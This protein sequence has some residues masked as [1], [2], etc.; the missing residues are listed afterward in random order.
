[1]VWQPKGNCYAYCENS[2]AAYASEASG[3]YGLYNFDYQ[4]YIG[5]S[6]NIRAALLQHLGEIEC[7]PARFQP[8]GFAFEVC[9][10]EL[11]AAKAERLIAEHCPVR[12]TEWPSAD[13]WDADA[14]RREESSWFFSSPAEKSLDGA[15]HRVPESETPPVIRKRFYFA[16]GQVAMLTVMFALSLAVIFFLGILTGESIQKKAS[17]GYEAPSVNISDT[18]PSDQSGAM[19][20]SLVE[21]NPLDEAAQSSS[22]LPVQPDSHVASLEP[23]RPTVSSAPRKYP[24]SVPVIATAGDSY[25]NLATAAE[26]PTSSRPA[27]VSGGDISWAVQLAANREKTVA[28]EQVTKLK[29]KGYDGYMVETE[30]DGQIWYRVRVGRFTTRPEAEALRGILASREDYRSPFI[31]N[32]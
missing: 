17:A 16:R 3:V 14:D 8:T 9:A 18:A 4:L 30:R 27:R 19:A 29:A 6:T 25:L 12:Q 2:I 20:S 22:K 26:K 10:G 1:M 11:R 28:E 15:D 5:E 21:R 32:D 31:T 23:D 24:V 7:H 13:S